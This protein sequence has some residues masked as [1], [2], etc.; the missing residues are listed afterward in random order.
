M[1]HVP[2][3]ISR[4]IWHFITH[5][6]VINGKVYSPAYFPS[7]IAARE[8]EI[9]IDYEFKIDS[10]KLR[11]MQ[12]MQ[13]ITDKNYKEP[14]SSCVEPVQLQDLRVLDLPENEDSDDEVEVIFIDDEN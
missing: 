13:E 2:R 10:S 7:P 1:G 9:L 4:A 3:E 8:L 6:G 14:I 12:R 5:G 11:F